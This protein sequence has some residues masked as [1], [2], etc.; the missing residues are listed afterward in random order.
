MRT[1]IRNTTAVLAATVVAAGLGIGLAQAAADSVVIGP[2]D[3]TTTETRATGHVDFTG[4]GLHVYTEGSTSTDKAAG[5]FDLNQPLSSAVPATME[6]WGTDAQPGQQLAFDA[7]GRSSTTDDRG[8]LVGEEVYGGVWWLTNSSSPSLQGAGAPHTGVGYGS[9]NWGTLQEWSDKYPNATALQ[10]GFSLGSGVKGDGVIPKM[11]YGTTTYT[12]SNVV[13]P[14]AT[15]PADVTG[16]YAKTYSNR[17][18]KIVFTSDA[19]QANTTLGKKLAWEVRVDGDVALQSQQYFGDTDVW[20][21]RF[22]KNSG[23]HVVTVRKNGTFV[24]AFLV[25][26][27]K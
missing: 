26:A 21:T 14:P 1:S 10:G 24:D 15:T 13:A 16:S 20:A 25:S 11:T 12:F 17:Y 27:K 22:A 6:W 9:N 18:L 19:Q 7:D 3:L 8:L 23:L 5:Y 2:G 4:D